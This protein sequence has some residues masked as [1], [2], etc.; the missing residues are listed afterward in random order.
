VA[1]AAAP[2]STSSPRVAAQRPR[3]KGFG[4]ASEEPFR[5]RPSD[6]LRVA[7]A[8]GAVVVLAV[9]ATHV[10]AAQRDLF[11][12]VNSLPGGLEALARALYGVGGLWA[13]A[14]VGGAAIVGRRWRL[15][16]DLLLAGALAWLLA[17]STALA[18]DGDFRHQVRAVVRLPVTPAFPSVHVALVVAV[19]RAASPYVTTPTRWLGRVLIVL[20][21]PSAIY[22]GVALPS[23]VS[24]AVVLG[25][26]VAA[27]VHLAL[28]SP[29][30]RPTP[31]HVTASLRD[32]GI[33]ATDVRLAGEQPRGQTLMLATDADGPLRVTVLGRDEADARLL[34]KAWR[35][36]AYRDGG[37]TLFLSRVQE[38]QHE[39]YATLL[40]RDRG[41]RTPPV[42]AAGTGGPGVALLVVR[43]VDGQTLAGMGGDEVTDGLLE[44]VW[45]QVLLLHQGRIAHGQL[46]TRHVVVTEAGPLLTGFGSAT[47][48]ASPTACIPDLAELLAT[49]ADLVGDERAT[50]AALRVLGDR[51]LPQVLTLLQPA[52]LTSDGRRLAA[53]GRRGL[54][55][56]LEGLRATAAGAAG[57]A[58]PQLEQLRRVSAGQ[59]TLAV[60]T[61]LGVVGLLGQ[62]SDPA[63]LVH[64]LR[65]ADLWPLAQ[66]V[67]LGVGSTVG[68]A[69]ALS[70]SVPRRLPL[71][72]NLR[73]QLAGVVSNLALPLGS[74]ALQV[75]FLQ[76]QGVELAAAF[77][78]AGVVGV[79]G[80]LVGQLGV[81]AVA[82]AL[83]PRPVQLE[84]LPTGALVTALEVGTAGLLVGSAVLLGVPVLRRRFYPPLA[85]GAGALRDVIASPR[86]VALLI[87]GNVLATV[88]TGLALAAC[89]QAF[90][91]DV[92]VWTAIALNTGITSLAAL[93]PIPSGNTAV[94]SVGLSG[95]LIAL[96][97]P[98]PTA[99]AVTLLDQ[100][101]ANYLPAVPGL[102]ALR[103]LLRS[104]DL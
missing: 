100:L 79:T 6:A 97:V 72:A 81:L 99:V 95:A 85:R 8:I 80:A 69:V 82:T 30:G 9:R 54:G 22:L 94:S 43:Q 28:G 76:R 68:F 5:R 2:A 14:L 38:V 48:A 36:L 78:A 55:D 83:S 15:A 46:N 47:T 51:D 86:R 32:L 66:A 18:V 31:A 58:V 29:G 34:A 92:S 90:D 67:A 19:V 49:T 27:L 59:L 96:G 3:S 24:A 45:E 35:F 26:G 42:L 93:V 21:V 61:L 50:A 75:R 44:A 20:L 71:W 17:R 88:L 89:L 10:S 60:G 84:A 91:L 11:E 57:V 4:P 98:P 64:A 101:A 53:G 87:G 102:F 104:A 7:A 77:A 103:S 13:A 1:T 40:A 56:R 65:G 39:A 12:T 25:W 23:A 70:G 62:V 16:R 41:V 74:T 33:D 73:V 52:A 37:P 63:Q